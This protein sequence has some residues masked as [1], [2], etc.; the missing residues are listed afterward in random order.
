MHMTRTASF[1]LAALLLAPL[2]ALHAAEKPTPASRPNI[3]FF[4]VDD[5]GWTDVGCM[6]SRFYETPNIDRLALQGMKFTQAYSACTV[7]SPTRAAI[8]TGQYPARLHITDWIPGHVQP[9]AKLKVP[10]W[11][12]HLPLETINIARLLKPEGFALASIG[13]WHLGNAKFWPDK[14]GFDLN[15][16]GFEKGH[17]SSYFSPYRIPTLPD[18]PKGEF[19]SDRLTDEALKFVEQNKNRPFFLYLPHYAVHTP[20]MAKPEVIEKYK[21]KADLTAPQHNAV[22]AGLIESVDDSIGR[23]MK[24]LDELK[25]TEN[26]IVIF[27]SDNGGLISSTGVNLGLR[28]GKGSAYEGGVR[29]PLIVKWPG[30]TKAG[31]VCETPVIS[32]DYLPTMLAM[33]GVAGSSKQPVDGE[34]LVPLLKQTGALNRDTIYWHYPHY[35]PGGATPY[36]AVREGDLKLIEFY[37]DNHV[38]LYNLK[39]DLAEKKDLAK[40]MPDQAAALRR[41]L[42]QWRASVGAQMPTPNPDYRPNASAPKSKKAKKRA[43]AT[44]QRVLEES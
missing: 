28:A 38:E 32:V 21:K 37:E 5:M 1:I 11:T 18:G 26:T 2:V 23:I 43:A 22:Y 14:Q 30:V 10:D 24:K 12:M 6:G 29:V 13:K 31:S 9:L 42:Q 15:V 17:P 7:C 41:K 39:D 8:L 35:H 19:L 33:D 20:L 27:N 3:I 44:I 34:S 25:L 36:G 16:A 4:L 40:T